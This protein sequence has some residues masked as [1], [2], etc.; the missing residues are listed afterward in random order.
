MNEEE[1]IV[2]ALKPILLNVV[3]R[4]GD[5]FVERKDIA[6]SFKTTLDD[7]RVMHF[8]NLTLE[9]AH[10]PN[11]RDLF[12]N[13]LVVFNASDLDQICSSIEVNCSNMSQDQMKEAIYR[14]YLREH[15]SYVARI[16]VLPQFKHELD[17]L[18]IQLY[19]T[20]SRSDLSSVL[21]NLRK[22]F[23][24]LGGSNEEDD[25]INNFSNMLKF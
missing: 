25:L 8:K 2:E 14:K 24:L 19:F 3:N 20:R 12:L 16:H 17:E 13:Q 1:N 22:A 23:V 9:Q 5:D 18:K 15:E 6:Q 21:D 7:P 11:M 10:H 4:L